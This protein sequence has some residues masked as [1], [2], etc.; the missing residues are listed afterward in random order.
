MLAPVASIYVLNAAFDGDR[1]T[2][3]VGTGPTTTGKAGYA[4]LQR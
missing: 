2:W 4:T 3:M 1:M